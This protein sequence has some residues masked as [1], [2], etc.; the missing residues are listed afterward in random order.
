M[1]IL[2]SYKCIAGFRVYDEALAEFRANFARLAEIAREAGTGPK[3]AAIAAEQL[4]VELFRDAIR[5]TKNV[6]I[7]RRDMALVV[8]YFNNS[9]RGPG[10]FKGLRVGSAAELIPDA[11]T[12][13][14]LIIR[15]LFVPRG[16]GKKRKKD[17]SDKSSVG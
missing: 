2:G 8:E 13:E 14:S 9:A 7:R 6:F 3:W 10:Q 17:I 1:G 5:P 16:G 12:V 4:G 11:K 15:G